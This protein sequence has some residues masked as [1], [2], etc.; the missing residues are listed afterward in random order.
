MKYNFLF[1]LL[2]SK[3]FFITTHAAI[4]YQGGYNDEEN[5]LECG[6]DWESDLIITHGLDKDDNTPLDMDFDM[7]KK[8]D[9]SEWPK[10]HFHDECGRPYGTGGE[11]K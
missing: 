3:F 5:D 2:G 11:A 7:D 1:T 9:D 4:Y 10:R 6:H 8:Y